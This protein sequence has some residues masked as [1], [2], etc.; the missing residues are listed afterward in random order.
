MDCPILSQTMISPKDALLLGVVVLLVTAAMASLRRRMRNR[1]S[2]SATGLLGGWSGLEQESA[3]RDLC[4]LTVQLEEL[5]R[6]IGAQI[7]TRFQKLETVIADA[8]QRIAS[9]EAL[10]RAAKDIPALDVAAGDD[11]VCKGREASEAPAAWQKAGTTAPGAIPS[12]EDP[13]RRRIHELSASGKTSVEIAQAVG[14]NPGEIELI[15]A[16]P[17]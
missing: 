16:L 2:G 4:E 7:D 15:L 10:L 5:S 3:K 8:D 6:R 14:R 17:R 13:L 11:R 12:R 9:L 1:R